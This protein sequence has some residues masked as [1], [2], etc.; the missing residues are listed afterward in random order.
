MRGS[1]SFRPNPGL[2]ERALSAI[3]STFR[4]VL[5]LVPVDHL[6]VGDSEAAGAVRPTASDRDRSDHTYAPGENSLPCL[7]ETVVVVRVVR[8]QCN[9]VEVV[10]ELLTG[11][12]NAR[13]DAL[14]KPDGRYSSDRGPD[15]EFAPHPE[16]DELADYT[17]PTP[18]HDTRTT[19]RR[20]HNDR[21]HTDRPRTGRRGRTAA[22]LAAGIVLFAL[23]LFRSPSRPDIPASSLPATTPPTTGTL[24]TYDAQSFAAVGPPTL[25]TSCASG[26]PPTGDA[27]CQRWD[28]PIVCVS[29]RADQY[30]LAAVVPLP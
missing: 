29:G 16:H 27:L 21:S 12:Q 20:P 15:D 25:P 11:N 9:G 7:G 13:L 3:A 10:V 26:L 23:I 1:R 8:T 28:C 18:G 2:D 30:Q 14:L 6:L 5:P 19:L 22:I 4:L 17:P 24:W